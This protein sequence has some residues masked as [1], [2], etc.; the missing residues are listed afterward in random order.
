M[1]E[2]N[3]VCLNYL[4]FRVSNAMNREANMTQVAFSAPDIDDDYALWLERQI[5]LI[6][7][8]QFAQLDIDNLIDELEYILSSRRKALRTRLAVLTTHLLKCEFQPAHKSNSWIRT[9][10]TQR[11]AIDRLIEQS[12]SLGPQVPSSASH[13]YKRALRQAAKETSLPKS[14]FP[15][16]L[17]YTEEHLLDFDFIP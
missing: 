14:A 2:L 4:H 7:E 17:P 5:E 11:N 1:Q 15:G 13:E 6:R 10:C 3:A 8:R 9:I 12:P 16:E